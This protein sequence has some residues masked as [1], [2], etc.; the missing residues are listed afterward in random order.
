MARVVQR[1][2]SVTIFELL[3]VIVLLG[4]AAG[5]LLTS[6]VSGVLPAVTGGIVLV[7]AVEVIQRRVPQLEYIWRRRASDEYERRYRDAAG[8]RFNRGVPWVIYSGYGLW[9]SLTLDERSGFLGAWCL[10]ALIC[11]WFGVGRTREVPAL[12]TIFDRRVDT[13]GARESPAG[14][15]ALHLFWREI[16]MMTRQRAL[17]SLDDVLEEPTFGAARHEARAGLVAIDA[18]MSILDQLPSSALIR[19]DLESLRDRLEAAQSDGARF[20]FAS[21]SSWSG[22]LELDGK[23]FLR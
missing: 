9:V 10:L 23:L 3:G 2:C 6:Y 13:S 11:A 21:I 8:A 1:A 19:A 14:G 22:K 4:I 7:A 5:A 16:V 18:A 20:C 17:P 12:R 15:R